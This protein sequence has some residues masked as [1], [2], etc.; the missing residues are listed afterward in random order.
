MTGLVAYE[1]TPLEDPGHRR[2]FARD[3]CIR[4]AIHENELRNHVSGVN[5]FADCDGVF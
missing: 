5:G 3:R 2:R 4:S 1:G